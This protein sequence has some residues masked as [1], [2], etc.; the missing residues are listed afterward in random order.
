MKNIQPVVLAVIRNG[1]DYLVTLRTDNDPEDAIENGYH[2]VWQL[3]GGGLEFGEDI[4]NCLHREVHEELGIEVICHTVVPKLY[5][6]VRGGMW[7]GLLIPY[8]CTMKSVSDQI[9][10]NNEA[11]DFRWATLPEVATMKCL[12]Y[13]YEILQEAEKIQNINDQYSTFNQH[14]T[15]Q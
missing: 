1:K 9:T 7:H 8:L 15:N 14:P 6:D 12:P 13:T 2:N 11:S 4:V 5:H 10:L 3:P